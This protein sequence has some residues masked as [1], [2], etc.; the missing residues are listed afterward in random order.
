[1]SDLFLL[2]VMCF[3]IFF[4][5]TRPYIAFSGYIWVDMLAPQ[6]LTYGFLVGK[7]IAMIMGVLC[8]F[9]LVLNVKKLTKPRQFTILFLLLLLVFWVTLTTTWALF[10]EAAW[11]KWDGAFKTI[12]MAVL[13]CFII[14]SKEQL[15]HCLIIF[16]LAIGYYVLVA[17]LKTVGGGAGYGNTLVSTGTNSGLAESSTLAMV[18]V[19]VIPILL[20]L[21]KESVILKDFLKYTFVSYG[22]IILAVAAVIGSGARTGLVAL[23]VLTFSY[24]SKSKQKIKGVLLIGCCLLIALIFFVDD[25]WLSRMETMKDAKSDASAQGRMLVWKWTWD[26]VKETP[27]GGGFGAFRANAGLWQLYANVPAVGSN[28]KAFHS[29][30]FETLGEHGYIGFTI[31]SLL[32]L[33][34]YR[35]NSKLMKEAKR[36]KVPDWVASLSLSLNNSLIVFCVSGIF[37]GVAFS[38]VIYYLIAFS[39]VLQKLAYKKND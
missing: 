34:T 15:E 27:L 32:L 7:P 16:S 14:T 24:W 25:D 4:G 12:L 31:Y 20:F 38:P 33:L 22:A 1:M 9:S 13:L 26:F 28:P 8:L 5:V 10:P 19:L 39:V 3:F 17:G 35:N 30:Y 2:I 36:G 29:I 11:F 23:A 37:I 18:A 21:K 6:T